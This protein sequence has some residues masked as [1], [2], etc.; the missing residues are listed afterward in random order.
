LIA[1]WKC[2]NRMRYGRDSRC[3]LLIG[4]AEKTLVERTAVSGSSPVRS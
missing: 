2:A 1:C 4:Q 3:E